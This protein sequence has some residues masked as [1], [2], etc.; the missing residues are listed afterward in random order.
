METIDTICSNF[1]R[2]ASIPLEGWLHDGPAWFVGM[3]LG[4]SFLIAVGIV[5]EDQDARH[6]SHRS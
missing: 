5:R 4:V 2:F 3:I 6:R 1:E